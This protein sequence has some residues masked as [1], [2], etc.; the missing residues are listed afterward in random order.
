MN[1]VLTYHYKRRFVAR[2]VVLIEEVGRQYGTVQLKA[3]I[4]WENLAEVTVFLAN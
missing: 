2:Q 4:P 3:I 1:Y